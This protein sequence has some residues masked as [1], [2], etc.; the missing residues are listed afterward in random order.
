MDVDYDFTVWPVGEPDWLDV[1][2]DD[3]PLACPI[4]AYSIP[5]VD[6][7]AFHPICPDD[8]LVQGRKHA[9]HVAS[10]KPVVHVFKEFHLLGHSNL[11]RLAVAIF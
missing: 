11:L 9:I 2:I 8:V 7:A 4:V 6:V 10:V 5:S 3:G 1:R